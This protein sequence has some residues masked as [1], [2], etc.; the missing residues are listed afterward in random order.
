MLG[1]DDDSVLEAFEKDEIAN[2]SQRNTYP[3]RTIYQSR[4]I[5]RPKSI[6]LP[7]LSDFG[8]A[9]FEGGNSSDDIQPE[10]YR[11]PEV[12]LDMNWSYSVDIWNIGAMVGLISPP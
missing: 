5:D 2:P 12:L 3:D 9:R 6:G 7:I 4:A 8:L 10:I 1:L 11:A